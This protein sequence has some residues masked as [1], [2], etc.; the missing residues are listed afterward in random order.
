MREAPRLRF[1][2]L[3]GATQLRRFLRRFFGRRIEAHRT[4]KI[5]VGHVYIVPHG[6]GL[7][8]AQPLGHHS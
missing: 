6:N 2:A 7:R 3:L 8:V 4:L 1:P 5:R